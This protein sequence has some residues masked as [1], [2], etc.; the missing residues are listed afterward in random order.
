M[1]VIKIKELTAEHK[2]QIPAW[3]E[4]WTNIGLQTN[5]ADFEKSKEAV[6]KAYELCE[7]PAPKDVLFAD[8]PLQGAKLGIEYTKDDTFWQTDR[9][10][11]F[12][13]GWCSYVSFF[14]DVMGWDD[15][16]LD[17]FTIDETLSLNSGW[18]FWH[19]DVAIICNRPQ[20]IKLD[21]EG[22]LH[23]ED[24]PAVR[25]RDGWSIYRWHGITVPSY[26]IEKPETITVEQIDAQENIEVRRV[27]IERYGEGDYLMDSG[28]VLLDSHPVG[29]LYK[30]EMP[31]DEDIIM[32]RVV[33][34]SAE[35]D[36]SFKPYYLRVPPTITKAKQAVS[37]T[38]GMT[39]D[40]YNPQQ[41][42]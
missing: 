42:S 14:R 11:Q 25:Y 38:F 16:V 41:E 34:S 1:S 20:Y 40:S 8:S 23:S 3:V 22:R 6:L 37:W 7:L 18:V 33:N 19:E 12:W 17:R 2:A 5:H 28:A 29:D 35:P 27:M 32:L 13:S 9:G 4:K 31:D 30:K 36:G 24:G 21:E 39:S 15:P 10:G 26:I